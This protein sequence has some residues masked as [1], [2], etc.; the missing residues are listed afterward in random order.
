MLSEDFREDKLSTA[1][2]SITL[3][4]PTLSEHQSQELV[5]PESSPLV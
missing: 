1:A 2:E 3:S 5:Y 4:L